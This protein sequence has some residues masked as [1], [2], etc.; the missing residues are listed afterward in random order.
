MYQGTGA[1]KNSLSLGEFKKLLH[2]H[3][4][5]GEEGWGL[6]STGLWRIK[7]I[8]SESSKIEANEES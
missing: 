7:C 1:G 8:L 6:R 4:S 3:R 5:P 2:G